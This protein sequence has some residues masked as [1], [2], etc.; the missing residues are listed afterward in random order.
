MGRGENHADRRCSRPG[1]L[2]QIRRGRQLKEGGRRRESNTSTYEPGL[3]I[4]EDEGRESLLFGL[5][6]RLTRWIGTFRV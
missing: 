5:I 6:A 1:S 4:G 2:E 3:M